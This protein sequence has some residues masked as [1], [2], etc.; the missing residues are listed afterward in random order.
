MISLVAESSGAVEGRLPAW[1]QIPHVIGRLRWPPPALGHADLRLLLELASLSDDAYPASF[2]TALLVRE[3]A[4]GMGPSDLLPEIRSLWRKIGAQ[5]GG[6]EGNT[7]W[8]RAELAEVM[9][10]LGISIDDLDPPP[11]GPLGMMFPQ[12]GTQL[13]GRQTALLRVAIL[14]LVSAG[15]AGRAQVAAFLRL[16]RPYQWLA[17]D[18]AGRGS[19]HLAGSVAK[20]DGAHDDVVVLLGL[21]S[22]DGDGRRR[23]SAVGSLADLADPLAAG[24]LALRSVDW[25]PTIGERALEALRPRLGDDLESAVVAIPI[26]HALAARSRAS[27]GNQDLDAAVASSSA[28]Q[29]RLLRSQD[30]TTRHHA[31][32]RALAGGSL[33]VEELVDL[34]VDDP[35]T[36]VATQAGTAAVAASADRLDSGQLARLLRARPLVRRAALDAWPADDPQARAV[37]LRHLFDRSPIVRSGAQALVRRTGADAVAP[38]RSALGTDR[39][40]VAM[41][42]LSLIG[43]ARD[44]AVV[45]AALGDPDPRLR[46]TAARAI[47]WLGGEELVGLLGPLV[48]DLAPI[49]AIAASR[50]L[51]RVARW[52]D[53]AIASR[54]LHRAEPGVRLAGLALSRRRPDY[55]RL[56]AELTGLHDADERVRAASLLDLQ[57]GWFRRAT[58]FAPR[59]DVETRRRIR[60]LVD[61]SLD[62]LGDLTEGLCFAAGLR[63]ADLNLG[64]KADSLRST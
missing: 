54:L 6:D 58:A 25:V 22:M 57:S 28:L 16:A 21:A 5:D 38:Y 64:P 24:F 44:R 43:D 48:D 32:S 8:P 1:W 13:N 30:A 59:V 29:R 26:L 41:I 14:R 34:A 3:I 45:V 52:L 42:E 51:R 53:P 23:E 40:A 50:R 12:R 9:Y 36:L 37:G 39:A 7:F 17:V 27:N 31:L 15:P 63:D 10:R 33:T 19:W 46:A 11:V 55:E 20:L 56:E 18:R 61:R 4:E 60:A 47:S 2:V 49:V 35:D 62:R